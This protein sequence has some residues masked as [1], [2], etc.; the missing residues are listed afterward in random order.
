MAQSV[1]TVTKCLGCGKTATNFCSACRRCFEF[2]AH[3]RTARC[4]KAFLKWVGN[5]EARL[6]HLIAAGF[7]PDELVEE[8]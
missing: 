7:S 3:N 1:K 2:C 4:R 8:G 5:V 6:D